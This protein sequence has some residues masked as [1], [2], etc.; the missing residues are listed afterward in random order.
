MNTDEYKKAPREW[1]PSPFNFRGNPANK[2]F[3]KA[4]QEENKFDTEGQALDFI[5]QSF[6]Q[7]NEHTKKLSD[8][9]AELESSILKMSAE[10]I[11]TTETANQQI[12]ERSA[13]IFQLQN[14]IT[15]LKA[16]G[17]TETDGGKVISII[18]GVTAE[19]KKENESASAIQ[20][21]KY[22]EFVQLKT[23]LEKALPKMFKLEGVE[24]V[25]VS[26]EDL[27]RLLV[28]YAKRDP[29]KEFPFLPIAKEI[30]AKF[31]ASKPNTDAEQE[32]KETPEATA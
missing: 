14:E 25:P 26:D 3:V 28:D 9:I 21:A 1:K 23:D 17:T 32:K 18:P 30:V 10:I 20:I 7:A 6:Q 8:K 4:F 11:S 12:Q 13:Y 24:V 29:S 22:A 2:A 19:I 16:G 5:L 15:V 27:L 31:T